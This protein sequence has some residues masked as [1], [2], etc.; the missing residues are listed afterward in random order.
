MKCEHRGFT[1][2]EITIVMVI[3]A[4]LAAAIVPRL[5]DSTNDAQQCA[6]RFNIQ[7]LRGQLEV[8]KTQ[9]SGQLPP[10]LTDL[11][12]PAN[13]DASSAGT[14]SQ[15][16]DC[17]EIPP[18]AATGRCTV[19]LTSANPIGSIMGTAGGWMYNSATGEIRINHKDYDQF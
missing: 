2:V 3:F 8:Y 10:T 12:L 19:T 13:V 5:T 18:D 1:L 6:A 4:A 7:V 14:G 9:N 15:G 11:T 16:S 17:F